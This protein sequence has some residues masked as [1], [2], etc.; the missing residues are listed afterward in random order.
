[1][2]GIAHW[3]DVAHFA[4]NKMLRGKCK[5]GRIGNEMKTPRLCS[6]LWRCGVRLNESSLRS[7]EAAV[8]KDGIRNEKKEAWL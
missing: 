1:M 7:I 5:S 8:R 6:S 2:A 4:H 3:F